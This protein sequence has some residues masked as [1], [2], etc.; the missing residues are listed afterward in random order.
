M[1]L[2]NIDNLLPDGPKPDTEEADETQTQEERLAR[3][4]SKIDAI[5]RLLAREDLKKP[6]HGN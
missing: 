1:D 6:P 3:I 2:V 4:E 5:L